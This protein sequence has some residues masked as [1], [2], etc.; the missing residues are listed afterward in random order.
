MLFKTTSRLFFG[1]FKALFANFE[2]FLKICWAWFAIFLAGQVIGEIFS[3]PEFGAIGP[4]R[5]VAAFVFV[6]VYVLGNASI[7]VAWHRCLLMEERPGWLHLTVGGRELRYALKFFAVMLILMVLMIPV[8]AL[9]WLF[10]SQGILAIVVMIATMVFFVL[11]FILR[12]SLVLPAVAMDE[13]LGFGE[14]F[15]DSEGLG[16]PMSLAAVG[17]SLVIAGGTF[18]VGLLAMIGG[19]AGLFSVVAAT[20][21]LLA[22]QVAATALQISVLTGG[23]YILRERQAN[24]PQQGQPPV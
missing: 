1:A 24:A 11:P 4:G 20:I 6:V 17:L 10:I 5:V 7:A 23:Y 22:L 9:L 12:F 15:R 19:G 18:A 14:A 16:L 3:P 8:A 2:T 21:L 13:P